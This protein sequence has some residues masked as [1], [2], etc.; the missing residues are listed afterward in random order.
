MARRGEAIREAETIGLPWVV[1]ESKAT[2]KHVAEEKN[3]RSLIGPHAA[4]ALRLLILTGARLGE[5]LDLRW[6][7]VDLERDLLL[8]PDSK[9]ARKCIVLYAPAMAVLAT[10]PRMGF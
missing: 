4:A 2:A 8:L 3:Q 1:G 5:I 6:E 9:T 10:L 7:W